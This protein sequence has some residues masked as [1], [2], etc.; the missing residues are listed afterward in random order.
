MQ[1][2]S[3]YIDQLIAIFS[4]VENLYVIEFNETWQDTQNKHLH[5]E[6][7]INGYEVNQLQHEYETDQ[8][9][10]SNIPWTQSKEKKVISHLHKE[11]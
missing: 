4:Q 9:C 6:I 5:A 8:S 1:S 3:P 11:N 7:A 10:K 2:L